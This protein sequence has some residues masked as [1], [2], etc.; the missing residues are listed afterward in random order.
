MSAAAVGAG[1]ET[2]GADVAFVLDF[3]LCGQFDA[4]SGILSC[5][6]NQ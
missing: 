5:S 1:V 6:L 2:E 3:F 4:R